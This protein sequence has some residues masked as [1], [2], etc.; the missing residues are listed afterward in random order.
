MAVCALKENKYFYKS[1]Q[2]ALLSKCVTDFKAL[3]VLRRYR[4]FTDRILIII[5][6]IKVP[7]TSCI[8]FSSRNGENFISGTLIQF[9]IFLHLK[10][11]I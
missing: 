3:S 9:F 10:K 6:N 11:N 4:Y 2:Y 8:R 1:T 7:Q 5:S